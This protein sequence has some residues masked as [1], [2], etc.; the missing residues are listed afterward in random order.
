MIRKGRIL[1][2][3]FAGR[4]TQE[5]PQARSLKVLRAERN[6]ISQRDTAHLAGLSLYPYWQIE[7]G[8]R[9]ATPEEKRAIA[10]ALGVP[11][12]AIAFRLRATS[13]LATA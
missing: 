13:D 3:Q 7:N 1:R 2:R 12:R 5:A 10:K 8:W 6:G 4:A 11:V 9:D